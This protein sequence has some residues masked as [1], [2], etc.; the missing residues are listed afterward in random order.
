MPII[1]TCKVCERKFDSWKMTPIRTNSVWSGN[2]NVG[3]L[4]SETYECPFCHA[5]VKTGYF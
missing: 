4:V 1:Q 5:E 2:D 3:Y